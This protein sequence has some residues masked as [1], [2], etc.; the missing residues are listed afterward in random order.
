MDRTISEQQI[1]RFIQNE[2]TAD[3][4]EQFV[5]SM[6][7]DKDLKEQV[8]IRY[9]LLEGTLIN[10]E[11]KARMALTNIAHTN[12]RKRVR[13][14]AVAC[15]ILL[16]GMG[17]WFGNQPLYSPQELYLI[18]HSIPV[19]ERARGGNELTKENA[20]TNA[21]LT[22]WY[23]QGKYKDIADWYNRNRQEKT[24]GRVARLHL[25]IYS[26]RL[27]GTR[28]SRGCNDY[29]F[30]YKKYRLSRRNRVVTALLL[31]KDKSTK[32]SRRTCW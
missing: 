13:W 26:C 20:V 21:L 11:E 12:N 31:F 25:I 15:I 9:L 23:E 14:I 10:N 4:R 27:V 2:M 24:I 5:L 28:E 19:L 1:D 3:E 18:Y 6:R 29:S 8:A 30:A 16:L 32:R 17:G 22:E 7:N